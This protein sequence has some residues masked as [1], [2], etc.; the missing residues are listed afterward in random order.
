MTKLTVK[1]L[2]EEIGTPVDRLLQQFSDA[3]INKKDGD[4][5]SEGEKQSLLVHLKK[6]HGSADESASPTRLTLQR[7]TRSTLSVAGSGGKSKDV[8]VEVRKKRT[9]VKASTLEEEKKA[10]QLKAEA[11]EQAKRDAEDAAVRE[12]EQKAQREAE[13]KAKRDA[14]AEV[15]AK[16]DAEQKAKRAETEKAKKEM[17]TKNDQAKKEA[18]ELKLRQEQEATRKA[19]AEA[20]KLVEEARKLA[21]ENEA[22]W[23]E[24]E[25]KK[26][27]AEKTADYHVTT[28]SHAR[29]AEDAADRKDEQQPRRRKKKAKPAE[30]AAPR[31]GRNQRGG[32]N[33]KPQVNKPTSMQ[34]GFD[35]TATV[36]KQVVAIGE[37]IVVSELASKMS[38]KATEVIKVMMK[39]GAMA[40]INQVIDQETAALVAEE[41]GHKV[42]LRKE[43]ELEEAVLSDR[44][45]TAEA[46]SRAPVVTIMGHVDHGKTS[47]L[48]YIRRAHVADAEAGGI[49][50]HIG[51]YHVETDNGMIT[52]LDTPGHAAFTAMRARGAQATDIVVLVV[53]AD[54]GVMPQTI[55]AI[56]HAKAA[57]VPLIV[58]VNKIDKEGANPDNVKNELAQYDVIPEEWGGENMFVHIS[59][60][61]GTNIEGLLEAI[62]LQSEVLELT[63]VK[64]GMASGVV[65]E[66]R[67]D[68]GRGPV[69]TVLVQSGTLNKGDIVL[70]GQEYGRVRAMRD[71]NGKDIDTAGPSI[72]V[73]ILGLSGVPASGDEAT[74]VRDERKARE[75]ANYRQG[76]F[77]DVKLARQQKAKLE[78][79]FANME[80]GEVAELNVVLK[81][82]V[83]GSVEAIADSLLKLSTD[84][85]K[86]NIVGSGVGGITETDATLAAA[87]NA[88]I[89]G[90]NVRA[91]ATARNTIQNENLDL[92]YYSIIYQLIDE[93]K[94]A[95]GGMLAPEFRQEIIGLAQVREVFKS[96][97]LGAIAGC[98]V[99]EGTIKRSN[100]IRV[101]RENVVIYEGELESLRRFKDDV[102][103]VKN[104]YECGIGVKNYNDVRA[105]DQIEVFEIVE[106]QRTLD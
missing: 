28:S 93:V 50:Q 94:Q 48:D 97:K 62:L 10:E 43:N 57:G 92:R 36:A 38:V 41:M 83:Q 79:M 19:E 70:C 81:A 71:E 29:E 74:V 34:H 105:G 9:Y 96:P 85:V 37:T 26:S 13:E 87:S 101:L 20:A 61:Q 3:G 47:T 58:A 66:S 1:A 42:V 102:A 91:D 82:D 40:T 2:S 60:K 53:A 52:F 75:V 100:P 73:E 12:L 51:A 76:K 89:L 59:A 69:A 68:K 14:E 99:T 23:K 31:G 35:K 103:E 21:E 46:V 4:S 32:R 11:E 30:A 22:R 45:N 55:E 84:E 56:Q 25:Q 65:V 6:E 8:Q 86:V 7:K 27:A 72:P 15:K 80:A 16:R 78:N 5:V 106:I 90:F 88:I 39:M 49:T 24:E 77:R 104:G 33:K 17:T 54:D 64:D 44:D 18:D 95:M 67:L 63:A 98:M